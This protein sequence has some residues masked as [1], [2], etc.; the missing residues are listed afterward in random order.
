M[1]F[2]ISKKKTTTGEYIEN[3]D[4]YPIVRIIEKNLSFCFD[5]QMIQVRKLKYWNYSWP[6]L[7]LA[8][9]AQKQFSENHLER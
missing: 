1:N 7:G 2:H 3:M 4:F 6:D 5:Q 9:S 8:E